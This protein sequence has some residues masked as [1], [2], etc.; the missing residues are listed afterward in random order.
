[1]SGYLQAAIYNNLNGH[2]GLAGWR[3]ASFLLDKSPSI[4]YFH[5]RWLYIICGCMTIPCG[6][7][8]FFVLPDVPSNC[9]VWYLSEEEK[10]FALARAIRNGKSQPTGKVD[11]ALLKRT[12]SKWRKYKFD[13]RL[14]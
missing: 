1:M 4:A 11:M 14:T 6:L 2:G 7:L 9:K 8:L 13:Y 5:Y 12:F 3:F 10:A